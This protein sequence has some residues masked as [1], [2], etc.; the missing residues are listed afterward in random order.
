MLGHSKLSVIGRRFNRKT[1]LHE[2]TSLLKKFE[3]KEIEDYH[4]IAEVLNDDT[5][6][7]EEI[8]K[9]GSRLSVNL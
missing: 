6:T 2:K 7:A 9:A 3:Q 1:S 5:A 8:G 4:N